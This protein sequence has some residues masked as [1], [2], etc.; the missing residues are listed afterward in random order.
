MKIT[1]QKRARGPSSAQIHKYLPMNFWDTYLL[2]WISPFPGLFFSY[3][4]NIRPQNEK[5]S[6]MAE[7]LGRDWGANRS[8]ESHR[9]YSVDVKSL[10]SHTCRVVP[11]QMEAT[12]SKIEWNKNLINHVNA[13]LRPELFN[14]LSKFHLTAFCL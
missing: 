4:E 9:S 6:I 8:V 14:L 11:I 13:G 7:F 1:L 2:F 3:T 5:G 10:I 12:I